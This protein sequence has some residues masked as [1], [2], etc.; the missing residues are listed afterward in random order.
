MS[1]DHISS[2]IRHVWGRSILNRIL[3]RICMSINYGLYSL[4]VFLYKSTSVNSVYNSS[5]S[6]FK[7]KLLLN[8]HFWCPSNQGESICQ[9]SVNELFNI[10]N[11][12]ILLL[13]K[14]QT[15]M[16]YMSI[17]NWADTRLLTIY[18]TVGWSKFVFQSRSSN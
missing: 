5:W 15:C 10:F 14:W 8:F 11:Q 2:D 12:T 9:W 13:I 7:K 4:R 16:A 17:L 3:R 18:M 1:R 6:T